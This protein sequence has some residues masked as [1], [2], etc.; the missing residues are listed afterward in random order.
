MKSLVH[1]KMFHCFFFLF[2]FL[3]FSLLSFCV[4]C[5][6]SILVFL[7][8]SI[9][10][11]S[12]F[13]LCL[14]VFLIDFVLFSSDQSLPSLEERFSILVRHRDVFL[15]LW[16][17]SAIQEAFSQATSFQV[18]SLPLS[19]SLSLL[20]ETFLISSLSRVFSWVS[21][22]SFSLRMSVESLPR[23]MYPLMKVP[24]TFHFFCEYSES[25][26]I[27]LFSSSLLFSSFLSDILLARARTTG[28]VETTFQTDVPLFSPSL[29]SFFS[30]FLSPLFFSHLE[31][32]SAFSSS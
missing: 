22:R 31:D 12:L 19:F 13:S 17:D 15:S 24:P 9:S 5:S 11:I 7:F 1:T 29:S 26:L 6:F 8:L 4:L 14:F 28:V 10:L 21:R 23:N 2:V 27:S 32:F 18:L 20:M 30:S 16:T 25:S 3:T